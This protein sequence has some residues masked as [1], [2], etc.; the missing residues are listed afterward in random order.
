MGKKPDWVSKTDLITFLRCPYAFWLLETGRVRF[1]DTLDARTA[2]FIEEGQ[3]FHEGVV[4]K[5]IPLPSEENIPSLIAGD[6]FVYGFPGFVENPAY[7]I[8]GRPDGVRT[9]HG[10]LLPIEIKSHR[11]VTR[12]DELELAFYWLLLQP[13]RTRREPPSVGYVVAR[14]DGHPEAIEVTLKQNR[15]A[16]VLET[17]DAI[18]KARRDGVRPSICSCRICSASEIRQEIAQ[19]TLDGKDLTLIRGIG[20]KH[21]GALQA[22]GIN[23]YEDLLTAD[24]REVALRL[25]KRSVRNAGPRMVRTWTFHAI[26]FARNQPVV[27][28]KARLD[29][30]EV[31]VLDCEYDD[32]DFTIWLIGVCIVKAGRRDYRHF[33]AD[34]RRQKRQILRQFFNLLA[35]YPTLPVVT[36]AGTGADLAHLRN[37]AQ[38]LDMPGVMQALSARHLDA[39]LF[40]TRNVRLP[41]YNFSLKGVAAHFG[42]QRRS[43]IQDGVEANAEYRDFLRARGMRKRRLKNSIL[44]Y[45]CDDLDSLI[46]VVG[47]LCEI[48][49][50][51]PQTGLWR[52]TPLA[53]ERSKGHLKKPQRL[54]LQ[55]RQRRTP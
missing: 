34:T 52:N 47:R 49:A 38:A 51:A 21:A 18:R 30:E 19:A 23:S 43:K 28:G 11:E 35:E 37:Q 20:R 3:I 22:I 45:N 13:L 50:S 27:F 26:S 41:I 4:A 7:K 15:F 8:L 44:R 29:C 39:Y 5:A 6:G 1:R 24:P 53:L 42:I 31:L 9:A 2:R 32:F 16:E 54:D 33:F 10:A 17:L 40:L 14:I 55:E 48:T 36:W 46:N 25:R 12:L